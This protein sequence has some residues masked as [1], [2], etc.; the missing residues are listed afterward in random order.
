MSTDFTYRTGLCSLKK[1]SVRSSCGQNGDKTLAKISYTQKVGGKG[2]GDILFR[3]EDCIK[4]DL[5]RLG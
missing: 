2:G 5:E 3:W 4:R 1:K